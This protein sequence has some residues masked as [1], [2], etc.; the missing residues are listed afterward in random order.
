MTRTPRIKNSKRTA[1]AAG[2]LLLAFSLTAAACGG[3]SEEDALDTGDTGVTTPADDTGGASIRLAHLYSADESDGPAVDVYAVAPGETFDA[4]TAVKLFDDAK[5]GEVTDYVEDVPAGTYDIVVVPTGETDAASIVKTTSGVEVPAG[6]QVTV[7]ADRESTSST[8][9]KLN[10]LVESELKGKESGKAAV[11]AYHGVPLAA[12][13]GVRVGAEGA[14]CL[15]DG[16]QL[17]F[18]DK[19]TVEVDGGTYKLGVFGPDDTDCSGAALIGPAEQAVEADE[20]YIVFAYG[21]SASSLN[22]L[23]A[24][25]KAG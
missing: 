20:A 25:I 16:A 10:L 5:F 24:V 11:T 15:A 2:S 6:A 23:P 7:V 21:T 1:M 17:S 9:L 14:G 13:D 12:A 19:A 22:L 18:G 3:D 4:T 8:D